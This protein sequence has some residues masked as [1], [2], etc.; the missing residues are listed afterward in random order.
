M[1]FA[2]HISIPVGNLDNQ[3]LGAIWNALAAEAAVWSKTWRETELFIFGVGHLLD[4]FESFAHD[5]V[6][7]GARTNA[8]A[9]MV[10]FDPMRQGNI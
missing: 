10:D 7:R 5:A 4:G 3:I 2:D 9:G 8:A 6:A 1:T